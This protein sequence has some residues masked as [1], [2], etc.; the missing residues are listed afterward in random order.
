MAHQDYSTAYRVLR[1]ALA[2]WRGTPYKEFEDQPFTEPLISHLTTLYL[3]AHEDR[4]AAALALGKENEVLT[5]IPPLITRYPLREGLWRQ[6]ILAQYRAGRQGEAL[7]TYKK[8]QQLLSEQLGIDPGKALQQLYLQILKQDPDLEPPVAAAGSRLTDTPHNLPMQPSPFI[9]RQR[10]KTEIQA[11]VLKHSLVTLLGSGGSGKSRLAIEVAREALG[12]FPGGVWVVELPP[13]HQPGITV[14]T[15]AAALGLSD[16]PALPLE[17]VIGDF[18][19][20]GKMLLVMDNCEYLVDEVASLVHGLLRSCDQLTILTT[21]QE[22]LDLP[23]ETL[24]VVTGLPIP[25]AEVADVS[26]MMDYDAVRLLVERA[27][28]VRPGFRLVDANKGAVSQICQ[29]LDGLPLAIELAAALVNALDVSQIVTRLDNR[30]ELLQRSAHGHIARHQTLRAAVDWSYGLLIPAERK[31]F[32]DVSVFVGGFSLEAAESVC[33]D[34]AGERES[35]VTTLTHLVD[36]SLIYSEDGQDG[37]GSPRRYRMLDTLRAFGLEQLQ[38][39]GEL[40]R[41]RDRHR[42][43]FLALAEEAVSQLRGTHQEMW[44]R[45][46]KLDHDNLRAALEWSMRAEDFETAGRIAG[47]LYPFWN[48]HGHYGEGRYWLGQI[49]EVRN[50]ISPEV[51][52]RVLLGETTL[53]VIQGDLVRA[54]EVCIEAASLARQLGDRPA[55]ASTLQYLGFCSMFSGELADAESYLGESLENA[56]AAHDERLQGWAYIFLAAVALSRGHYGR[57]RLLATQFLST[58]ESV[59]GPEV[60]GWATL[61]LGATDWYDGDRTRAISFLLEGFRNFRDLGAL[62]GLSFS[63]FM[64][65]EVSG[66]QGNIRQQV[67]L[68]AAAE[69]LR[70]SIAAA[71]FPFLEIWLKEAISSARK[72]MDPEEFEQHWQQGIALPLEAAIAHAE[73]A[74]DI[75]AKSSARPGS[76]GRRQFDA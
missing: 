54:Q 6:L 12:H 24:R 30:F 14:Q 11:L 27:S 61:V 29:V 18:L 23:E 20:S 56:L 46:L 8:V 28:A 49:L 1:D 41:M 71:S 22:R 44:L 42:L 70:T 68:M 58:P 34:H 45:L 75:A 13:L 4:F 25:G 53:A 3:E 72:A 50:S 5:G 16:H 74:L 2:L 32:A 19:D 52:V 47:S 67:I 26:A 15:V 48:L 35:L 55:L 76:I 39:A 69:N 73:R 10:E 38:A 64:S 36:K 66:A 43:H 33:R 59:R 60:V 65:A 21:S 9:G 62:W 7:E 63:M 40:Q 17:T 57:A 51:R 31:L 37:E